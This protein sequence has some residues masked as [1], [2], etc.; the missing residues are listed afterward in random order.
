[1]GGRTTVTVVTEI[2][3]LS[4]AEM[5]LHIKGLLH[6]RFLA[7]SKRWR[8]EKSYILNVTLLGF[9]IFAKWNILSDLVF[10]WKKSSHLQRTMCACDFFFVPFLFLVVL[11]AV[12]TCTFCKYFTHNFPEHP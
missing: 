10:S 3:C 5:R 7:V 11:I 4:R 1:M 6:S 12:V 2:K 9:V 8:E